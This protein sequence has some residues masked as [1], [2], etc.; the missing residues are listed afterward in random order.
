VFAKRKPSQP[1]L[2]L[3]SLLSSLSRVSETDA[4]QLKAWKIIIRGREKGA[5]WVFTESVR[6]RCRIGFVL[7]LLVF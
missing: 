5:I 2:S 4:G 7:D 6:E 1:H 3:F